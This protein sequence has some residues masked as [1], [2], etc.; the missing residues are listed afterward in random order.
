MGEGM[1]P[2]QDQEV[3]KYLKSISGNISC[4]SIMMFVA[5]MVWLVEH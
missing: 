1:K 2:E 5:L 3:V 4:M